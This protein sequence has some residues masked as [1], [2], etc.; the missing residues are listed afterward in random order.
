MIYYILFILLFCHANRQRGGGPPQLADLMKDTLGFK[1]R[2]LF[3]VSLTTIP[4]TVYFY[5]NYILALPD[6]HIITL[7]IAL[8]YVVW[9][10]RKWA[11]YMDIGT[12]KVDV[13]GIWW[14]DWIANNI[15]TNKTERDFLGMSLRGLYALPTFIALGWWANNYYLGFIGLLFL[16]QGLMYHIPY[17]LIKIPT[18]FITKYKYYTEAIYTHG[19]AEWLMGILWGVSLLLALNYM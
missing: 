5:T 11:T 10:I 16:L 13:P 6:A 17:N 15:S 1:L 8:G 4:L 3:I 9:G 19:I 12:N 14:I 7:I 2:S 18:I